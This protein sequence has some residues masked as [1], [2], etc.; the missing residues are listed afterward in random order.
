MNRLSLLLLLGH[1]ELFV[2][3]RVF[4]FVSSCLWFVFSTY[5]KHKLCSYAGFLILLL[6]LLTFFKSV[7][8]AFSV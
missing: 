4:Y 5:E 3:P 2:F 8:Y 1:E 7:F 6:L